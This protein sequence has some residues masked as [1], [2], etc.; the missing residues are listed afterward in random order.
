MTS[1]LVTKKK[2]HTHGNSNVKLI[3]SSEKNPNISINSNE[4]LTEIG[5][6]NPGTVILYDIISNKDV[7]EFNYFEDYGNFVFEE[8]DIVFT[9][10]EAYKNCINC[11]E[12][13][14]SIYIYKVNK[15]DIRSSN[16]KLIFSS[17]KNP[18]FP[19]K[20]NETVTYI[21]EMNPGTVMLYDIISNEDL[22]EFNYFEDYGN[23]VFEKKD[24]VFTYDEAYK[25]C[26][27]CK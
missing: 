15:Y 4:T 20:S 10:D 14:P 18:N 12:M 7:T 27:N 17:E 19:I 13:N 9:Y 16:V 24:I 21:G 3:F 2:I 23:F 6:M 11:N 1:I 5:E 26:I 8:K 25:M 22:T